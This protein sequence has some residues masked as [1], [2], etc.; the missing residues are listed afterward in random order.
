M[1]K[2]ALESGGESQG[3]LGELP[4]VTFG[5]N[6]GRI[7]LDA[8]NRKLYLEGTI[9]IFNRDKRYTVQD[10][11]IDFSSLSTAA[12]GILIFFE[13][14]TQDFYLKPHNH[15]GTITKTSLLFGI[16]YKSDGEWDLSINADYVLN[17]KPKYMPYDG[18]PTHLSYQFPVEKL[19]GN[20]PDS[21]LA[22]VGEEGNPFDRDNDDHTLVYGLFDDLMN[23]APPGFLMREEI[24]KS[25]N[26]VPIYHYYTNPERAT[27][28]TAGRSLK[29]YPKIILDSSIHGGENLATDTV[30]FLLKR[31]C[32]DWQTDKT[33]EY[34][35]NYVRLSIVPLPNPEDYN[36][37]QYVGIDNINLN[38]DFNYNWF[39]REGSGTAPNSRIE[40]VVMQDFLHANADAMMFI[41]CHVRGN[42]V[43]NDNEIMWMGAS[44]QKH[45]PILST[46]IEQMTRKWKRK[47]PALQ[48][49]SGS[50]GYITIS[51]AAGTIKSYAH[52]VAGIP[53][54]LWEGFKGSP[55]MSEYENKDVVDMNVDYLGETLLN[56]IKYHQ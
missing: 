26:G 48:S 43:T 52:H 51:D 39:E 20:F 42:P 9:F 40:S 32:E 41:D 55:T 46:T 7:N 28:A 34:L 33:L 5:Q 13:T 29:P 21:D 12:S 25:T 31:I 27:I 53:S 38:R 14:A 3:I 36:N 19:Y 17:G 37:K 47:Y 16:I 49:V 22:G 6:G 54:I 23:N 18:V 50:L 44:D 2:E 45:V 1:A 35:R 24:G 30:Y 15:I 4:L 10:V 8:G 56:V 11:E